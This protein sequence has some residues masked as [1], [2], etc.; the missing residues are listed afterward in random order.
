MNLEAFLQQVLNFLGTFNFS[1]LGF[2]FII[3]FIGEFHIAVPY[4]LETIWLLSGFHLGNGTLLPYQMLILWMVAQTGRQTG[5]TTLFYMSMLGSKPLARL[6]KRF[7][8]RQVSEATANVNAKGGLTAR[9]IHSMNH[10]T[11]FS[12]A[13]GRL[14]WLRIPLTMALG[15]QR[16]LKVLSLGVLI[17]GLVWDGIYIVIGVIGGHIILTPAE[18]VLYSLV[19]LTI[20]YGVTLLTRLLGKRLRLARER[21][22]RV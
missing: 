10:P 2:L 7:F 8:S 11:A 21:S 13:V 15:I 19:G 5:A 14:L 20:F 12:V 6:Y 22:N 9:V 16:R 4:L 17:S 3:C 18:M 1:L